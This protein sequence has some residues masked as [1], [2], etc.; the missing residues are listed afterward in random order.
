[1]STVVDSTTPSD[2]LND[3]RDQAPVWAVIC[4]DLAPV[5]NICLRLSPIP[6]VIRFMYKGSTDSLPIMPYTA[7]LSDSILWLF[8]GKCFES[9]ADL[10]CSSIRFPLTE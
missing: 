9:S 3:L 1:M 4:G 5:I 10:R 6:T 2:E 8:F 7:L